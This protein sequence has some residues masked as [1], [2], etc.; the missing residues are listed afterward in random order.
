MSAPS[1]A[2]VISEARFVNETVV[3]LAWRDLNEEDKNGPLT[4]YEVRKENT[5][6]CL[7]LKLIKS[8][9]FANTLNLIVLIELQTTLD[10]YD[11]IAMFEHNRHIL[12]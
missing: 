4:S 12:L 6:F 2:P 5:S 1:G 11:A 9:D 8:N 10:F 7:L 3:Y